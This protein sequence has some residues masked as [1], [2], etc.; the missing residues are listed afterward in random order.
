MVQIV[1]TIKRL[2]LLKKSG[3]I[4]LQI[5][6]KP[7]EVYLHTLR[8]STPKYYLEKEHIAGCKIL[9]NRME[10]LEMLPHH[11]NVAELGVDEGAFSRNILEISQPKTLTLVDVWHTARYNRN[12][13]EGVYSKYASEICN[14]SIRIIEKLSTEAADDCEDDEFDWIYIDTDHSYQT[15]IRELEKWQAKIKQNGY[16]CGHDYD[17]GDVVTGRLYGVIEAVSEFCIKYNWKFKYLTIDNHEG[18][19]FCIT[20]NNR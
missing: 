12:K 8:R 15:T 7:S 6:R 1:E 11:G 2:K 13:A 5:L 3:S 14:V 16:I 20:R 18:R 19:S 17:M 4:I 10:L 9:V